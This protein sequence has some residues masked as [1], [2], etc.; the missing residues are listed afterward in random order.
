MKANQRIQTIGQCKSFFDFLS[1]IVGKKNID[2]SFLPTILLEM[3]NACFDRDTFANIKTLG[4][5]NPSKAISSYIGNNIFKEYAIIDRNFQTSNIFVETN[6]I[7]TLNLDYFETMFKAFPMQVLKVITLDKMQAFL[8]NRTNETI[9]KQI[10]SFY[11]L[12]IDKSK[13]PINTFLNICGI[14]IFLTK[15]GSFKITSIRHW[16]DQQL[17][18][19]D[20][21]QSV[22]QQ[23]TK[24]VYV[25]ILETETKD[26][27]IKLFQDVF[28]AFGSEFKFDCD[29]SKALKNFLS[30]ESIFALYLANLNMYQIQVR[31]QDILNQ[32]TKDPS[33]L[34]LIS[35][36]QKKVGK[37][38]PLSQIDMGRIVAYIMSIQILC[39][40]EYCKNKA[41]LDS[42][43]DET[44]I[45]TFFQAIYSSYGTSLQA[46]E[47]MPI[48][49]FINKYI[50]FFDLRIWNLSSAPEDANIR[51]M[52][53]SI[54]NKT[55]GVISS[56]IDSRAC[57]LESLK[58]NFDI[59]LKYYFE[60]NKKLTFLQ[61]LEKIIDSSSVVKEPMFYAIESDDFL[62][63][64]SIDIVSI[65]KNLFSDL[66]I[67][68]RVL[69]ATI[70]EFVLLSFLKKE[71]AI[72]N[73][74]NKIV[75]LKYED[76]NVSKGN[77]MKLE[78][79]VFANNKTIYFSAAC[80]GLVFVGYL[81]LSD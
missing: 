33:V 20:P 55:T 11:S 25:S 15:I 28:K 66:E 3:T 63:K 58:I 47:R 43:F 5:D 10:Q 46:F 72:D 7:V 70:R 21:N 68:L 2:T 29:V 6:D 35:N 44:S 56:E 51:Y 9:T 17:L 60:Q 75:F 49:D 22:I 81:A 64:Q 73:K 54:K 38:I 12:H 76:S 24:D 34:T 26:L 16:I 8:K 32:T 40:Q 80:I 52:K 53:P 39:I 74:T 41:F 23:N 1:T 18:F 19:V 67:L 45:N 42:K 77:D 61:M 14:S 31:F 36:I 59:F 4:L 30:F 13:V 48:R 65:D 27:K 79:G 71:I 50:K 57:S 78:T 69:V 37:N 62:K